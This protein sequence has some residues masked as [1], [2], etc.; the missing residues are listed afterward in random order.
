MYLNVNKKFLL[1]L[2]L[3]SF[4]VLFD[5]AKVGIK[6]I[7]SKELLKKTLRY[8]GQ[9][10][11]M[12]D[13]S[14]IHLFFCPMRCCF[15]SFW[16]LFRVGNVSELSRGNAKRLLYLSVQGSNG[17]KSRVMGYGLNAVVGVL[18]QHAQCSHEP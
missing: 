15:L 5:I 11:L 16:L 2:L 1:F 12:S 10:P 7:R 17:V 13:K 3:F 14:Q 18:L 9:K 4:V 8:I 6:F